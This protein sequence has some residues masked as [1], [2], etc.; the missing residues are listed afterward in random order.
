VK[1]T[2]AGELKQTRPFTSSEHEVLLGLQVAAT[3][4]A[5]PTRVTCSEIVDRMIARDPDVTRLLDRLAR[6]GLVDR[7]RSRTDRRVIT[8]GITTKGLDL[9]KS[10][11]PAV[12]RMPKAMLGHLGASNLKQLARL[13]EA[14][15]SER[16]AFP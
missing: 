11:D 5:H 2:V 12:D 9:L 7:V 6:R 4:G 3:R 14:V 15:L 10:L 13:L 8:V 16:G 1:T